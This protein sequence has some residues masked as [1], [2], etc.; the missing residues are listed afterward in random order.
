MQ[1]ELFEV[2]R[3]RFHLLDPDVYI[4]QGSWPKEY[5]P[6]VLLD[7][8]RI[9]DVRLEDWENTSALERF[10]DLD[11]MKGKK[12]TL[13]VRLPQDLN[14]CKRLKIYAL[15]GNEKILWFSIAV[16]DLVRRQ[17]KPFYYIEEEKA[18]PSSKTLKVRGWAVYRTPVT[19]SVYD[20]QG[21]KIPCDIQ[22]NNRVDAVEMFKETQV[23]S[24][25][26]FYLELDG[27][28]TKTVYLVFRAEGSKAVYPIQM[29]SAFIVKNKVQ[30]LAKKGT[31]YLA[32]HGV[33]ALAVKVAGKIAGMKK[34]PV[35][36]DKWLPRHLPTS[37]ELDRQR[38]AVFAVRPKFSIVVPLYKTPLLYLEA[39]IASV[40]EQTYPEWE[41]CLSDGS[42]PDSPIADA[43]LRYAGA[44][45]R[46]RV[47][48]HEAPL[49]ISENTNAA[50][51]AAT[52]EFIVFA[53]HDDVLTPN[54]LYECVKALNE[55]PETEIFYSDEDKMSM[56]GHKFFQPHF[57]PDFNLDL[58]CT[59]NYIC[60]LFVARRSVIEKAGV[61]RPE[62]DGAQD[63]DFIFRCIEA[64]DRICHIPKILYHW[65]SHE[66][67]TSENPESKLYAF[68]AGQRAVQAHYDRLG[69]RAEV[70]KGEYL[71]LYR[72]RFLRD[73]DPLI[74]II[75]PNKDHT[76]DLDRCIQSIEEKSTYK[77]YEYII[78][79][80]NSTEEETF[81]YYKKLELEN[82]RAHV[83]YWDGIFN[84]SLINNFGAQHAKGEY[85]LLLNNDTEIINPDCLEELLGYCM[86]DDVGAV[87]AR[88]Y[89]EDDTIQHAGVVIGF[90]GIAGHCFVM[91]PRGYTGYC[92]R[93]ICA[94]DY[95]A[96]TA[97]CMM[98][99]R[100]IFEQVGGLSEE[101]QVAFN[102][103]DFCMKIRKAGKLIVY[104]PYAELYHYESKSRGLEDT[105]EKV[106]RFNREIAIFEKKWPDIFKTGDPYYNPNLTLDSQDF[107][108][109][110]I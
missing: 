95:S 25:C 52:G 90:G 102:D 40:K 60:H 24:K 21:K 44:D 46:I 50:I 69:I 108:L 16:R 75:I 33:K 89:F 35:S 2:K 66:D 63:Y 103:I 13:F 36:Y 82:P 28:K 86:R 8:R 9:S 11:L 45:E 51:A 73:Y 27:V 80:N 61:L 85:F 74:S 68:D 38:Q 49:K 58:L 17:G 26:G 76:E 7:G 79:E 5:E 93:I 100:S 99:K 1:R 70:S 19:I 6:Q 84:Y 10:A 22:R 64:S 83:I 78:V 109:R 87:G 15:R 30:R 32:S 18:S 56:D 53:D 96:V 62:F 37:A 98:V 71:G 42:G 54:A 47:I 94:Q 12:V 67:S 14:K 81:E 88:L 48:S 65:R 107:S 57:K 3:E 101:L 55:Q 91:Q 39:L 23:E 4:L 77:N 59:V 34:A 20:E 105:P 106:A 104:N 110:R 97:A 43:L 41:L 72:T 29:Q 92:H 31:R